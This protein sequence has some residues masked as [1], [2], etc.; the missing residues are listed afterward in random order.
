VS[1][2][3]LTTKY[4]GEKTKMD[5][6]NFWRGHPMKKQWALV[7]SLL[8]SVFLI[9]LTVSFPSRLQPAYAEGITLANQPDMY[10][11]VL[12]DCPLT[13]GYDYCAYL[14]LIRRGTPAIIIDHRHTDASKIPD[15]WLTKAKNLT[16]HY[17]HT[18]HGGQVT[19]GLSWLEEQ[20]SK[21]NVAIRVSV[22]EGLPSDPTAL[23][24]Y[25]GNPP[26]TYIEPIDYWASSDGIERTRDVAA[27]GHYTYSMWSWC[28]QQ[29]DNSVET[30]QEYL[31][32]MHQFEQE[33]PAMRFILMT[34]HT[35]GTTSTGILFRNNN[36]V[37]QYAQEHGKV[38][39]DFA[40]IETYDPE[41]NG[42]YYNNGDGTCTWCA[43]YCSSHP[44]F[45]DSLPSSCT[46]SALPQQARLFCKLKG[47]AFWW[48]MA[49]LA[50]WDGIPT[51]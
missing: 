11:G 40:D 50:G 22:S 33:F 20:N 37:R 51:Q 26:E 42:P 31:D 32:T 46:H 10:Y 44:G 27:T 2:H 9:S 38:L 3:L 28:G 30:V 7:F 23:R 15:E 13:P 14:P 24:I 36:L 25:D 29:S 41:G 45:C 4:W 47:Q 35:D 5:D 12:A 21:Y 6:D 8:V 48:M 43:T 49:R 1:I 18:S 17:A 19:S 16:V 34:G 39:F